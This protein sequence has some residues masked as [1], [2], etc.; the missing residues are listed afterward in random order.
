MEGT[1]DRDDSLI[2]SDEGDTDDGKA[3]IE[4]GRIDED[5]TPD[6]ADE[7][8]LTASVWNATSLPAPVGS[9]VGFATFVP[10]P[11]PLQG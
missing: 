3:D 2:E 9:V 5:N 6:E 10:N 1:I 8:G 7:P 4:E 11:N